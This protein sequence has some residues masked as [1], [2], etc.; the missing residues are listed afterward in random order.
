M[1]NPVTTPAYWD[2][3]SSNFDE[4]VDHGLTTDVAYRAWK[5]LL[6]H[7]PLKEKARVLDVG[8]GTG[9]LSFLLEDMGCDVIGV[10]FSGGMIDVANDKANRRYSNAK[11]Q[12]MDAH[13]LSFAAGSFDVL[14]CRHLLWMFE[15]RVTV[16]RTWKDLL[17]EN[18]K[19]ILIEGYWAGTGIKIQALKD[20]VSSLFQIEDA[21]SLSKNDSLW[22]KKVTDERYIIVAGKGS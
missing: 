10:D 5:K 11:F 21:T 15:D 17:S 14:L 16:L 13:N 3:S 6:E 9:S 8:C 19:I 4:D 12:V 2:A 7:Y 18:G 20:D 1:P 22:G